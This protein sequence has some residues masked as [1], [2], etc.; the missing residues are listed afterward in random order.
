MLRRSGIALAAVLGASLAMAPATAAA[1]C[2]FYVNTAGG[3]LTNRA[4]QVVLMREGTRTVLTMQSAYEGPPEDFALVVPVPVVL[5]RADVKTLPRTAVER[6]ERAS[7]P[8][9]VEYWEQDPCAAAFRSLGSAAESRYVV[10][11]QNITSPALGTIGGRVRVEARFAVGEYDVEVLSARDSV[12]LETWLKGQGYKIPDGAAAALRPY[13]QAGMKFFVARVAI[14]RV[15]RE[16][17]GRA[18]LSPLRVDYESERFSLPIRLGLLN[19]DGPQ[20]LIVHIIARDRYQAANRPNIAIPTNLDV[21]PATRAAFSTFYAALFDRALAGAPGAVVTEYAWA[22][23]WCDPCPGPTVDAWTVAQLGGDVLWPVATA[24]DRLD[25]LGNPVPPTGLDVPDDDPFQPTE[26][27]VLLRHATTRA[28]APARMADTYPGSALTLTRLHLRYGRDD[29]GEDLVF[30]VAPAITGGR[31][32]RGLGGALPTGA[33]ERRGENTFQAR[34]AIRHP[35]PGQI[36]CADPVRGV[37]GDRPAGGRSETRVATDLAFAPREASLASFLVGE[38]AAGGE[39][40][41]AA[42]PY[43]DPPPT[44]AG[45]ARCEVGG[46]GPAAFLW[47][48]C[49][50]L[51][52]RRA[53][54]R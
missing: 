4:T 24:K 29:P 19:A 48:V 18:T 42:P 38:L 36:W 10:D 35:W 23:S 31:E 8:R 43:R 13:V 6:V 33:Q 17:D 7:A 46:G 54:G 1:F 49:L 45:C 20:D 2:G 51:L 25:R 26:R 9:L 22:L 52:R 44:A 12:G 40:L 15:K 41:P 27:R 34:Y 30:Q 21:T 16:A 37:W 32:V 50:G 28:A 39:A 14:G 11:G 53:R 3:T 47:L 5:R